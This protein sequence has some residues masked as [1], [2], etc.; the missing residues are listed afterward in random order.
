MG[1]ILVM[2]FAVALCLGAVAIADKANLALDGL[3]ARLA[4]YGVIRAD[5][6]TAVLTALF[7]AIVMPLLWATGAF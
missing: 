4:R 7:A 1:I 3:T 6:D 2:A 5:V